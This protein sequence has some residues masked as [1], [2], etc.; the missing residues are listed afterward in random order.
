MSGD[1][2]RRVRT[3]F[4]WS[5]ISSAVMRLGSLVVG[6]VLARILSPEDFGV[7]AIA[8]MVQTILI[9]LAE[10]GLAADLVRHGDL[11]GRGPTITTI[12]LLASGSLTLAM[13]MGARSRWP[14]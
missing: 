9:N 1:L 2:G 11:R 12:A 10:L 7:F 4:V 14:P 13:W 8:L 3:G 5:A 6:I